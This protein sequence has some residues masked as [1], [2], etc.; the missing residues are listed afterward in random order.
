MTEATTEDTRLIGDPSQEALDFLGS[1]RIGSQ[2]TA[3]RPDYRAFVLVAEGLAPGEPDAWSEALLS[4]AE[5]AAAPLD[6]PH[7]ADWAEAFKAFG[8]KPQRT[9]PSVAALLRRVPEL[10]R[11]DRLTDAYNAISVRHGIP[12]GGE[13]IDTYVGP[14]RLD[15]AT[16]DEPF[17]TTASGEPV[18]E[19]PEPGEVVWRDD[20]GVTCRRWNWRQCTR[21]RLT[22]GTTR[23]VFVFDA[24]G[25]LSDAELAA[26]GEEF[27][28]ALLDGNPGVRIASRTVRS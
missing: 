19:H 23:A 26:A 17:E 24:L 22:T 15:R 4:G 10:P 1:V 28:A 27:T 6:S 13:D 11:V 9:R 12:L 20:A 7:V 2:V 25:S 16:G 3:L 18:I 21:T 14:L 5:S 8:A